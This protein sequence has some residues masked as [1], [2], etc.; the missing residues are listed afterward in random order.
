MTLIVEDGSIVA[1]ANTYVS[2]S[3]YTTYAAARGKTI[4]SSAA[5][6]EQELILAMDYIESHRNQFQGTKV[7]STQPLQWPRSGVYIDGFLIG[8]DEIP[9]DLKNAQIEAAILANST[10]L[11]PSGSTQNV[12]SEKLGE[13]QISYFQGGSWE[14][15]RTDSIDVYL[16]PLLD[17]DS[18]LYTFR[19]DRA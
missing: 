16:D 17:G 9:Q 18:G 15:L 5:T 6:R 1:G 7:S 19:V 13:L 12:Q 14:T 4:G 2:D 8:S 10:A 11:L 3:D